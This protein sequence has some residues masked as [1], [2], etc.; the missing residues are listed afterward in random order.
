MHFWGGSLTLLLTSGMGIC[1]AACIAGWVGFLLSRA[2]DRG[3][4]ICRH[5]V[6][7]D[8]L[9]C[10]AL[11]LH[12]MRVCVRRVCRLF[13]GHAVRRSLDAKGPLLTFRL[14]SPA[15][16]ASLLLAASILPWGLSVA[17]VE[18]IGGSSNGSCLGAHNEWLD[19]AAWARPWTLPNSGGHSACAGCLK[20]SGARCDVVY[21]RKLENADAQLLLRDCE[22]S[23]AL[24]E[25]RLDVRGPERITASFLDADQKRDLM[26]AANTYIAKPWRHEVYLQLDDYPHPILPHEIAHV[27]ASS[28][29][30]GPFRV[31]GELGVG[32][33]IQVWWKVSRWLPHERGTNSPARS[34]VRR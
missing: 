11:L 1:L 5:R 7:V 3:A 27:V 22:E 6:G 14:G 9:R 33:R 26:G 28:F 32:C 34:G 24:V 17:D 8:D 10:P 21:P 30:R 12:T 31:G 23:L 20:F 15:T 29:G 2:W 4:G 16:I 19:C 25:K 18:T 13:F